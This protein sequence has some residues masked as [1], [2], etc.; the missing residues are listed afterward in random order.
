MNKQTESSAPKRTRSTAFVEDRKVLKE[1]YGSYY[2]SGA[3][4]SDV[5][6]WCDAET[7]KLNAFVSNIE[8]LRASVVVRMEQN[9]QK[10]VADIVAGL[11]PAALEVLKALVA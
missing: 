10:K 2:P 5:L 11:D 4:D 3:T 7:D 9:T 6:L 8:A 1:K